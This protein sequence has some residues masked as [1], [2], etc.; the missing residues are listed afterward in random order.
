MPFSRAIKRSLGLGAWFLIAAI[1][2]SHA[3]DLDALRGQTV[4]VIIGANAGGTTDTSAR[5]F[6]DFVKALLPE[7]TMRIQNMG[8]SGAAA[9]VKE[10]Q[11][12][13]GSV[14]TIA[15]FNYGPIYNQLVSPEL[16]PYDLS[17][18]QWIGAMERVQRVLAIRSGLGG[19]TIDA[20]RGLDR[21][22]VIGASDAS[23][24]STIEAYLINAMFGLGVRV[25]QG[26]SD[27]Q[28]EVLLLAG[29]IEAEIGNPFEMSPKF[30]SGAEIPVLRFSRDTVLNIEGVPA[31]ADIAPADVPDELIF[32]FETLDKTGRLVTASPATDP[33]VVASLRAA[34]DAVTADPEFV[35]AMAGIDIAV[36]PT[37]GPELSERLERLLGPESGNLQQIL[38]SYL[39]CG[40]RMSAEGVTACM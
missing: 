16:A 8:G 25:L 11:E 17:R 37:N 10:V 7:T 13:E 38:Q 9:A 34:F 21:R 3:D 23:S 33:A 12:A 35:A 4:R 27:S 20:L 22:A 26:S 39:E 15:I 40:R 32:F 1:V 6:L 14:V 31:I 19:T 5:M 29:E 28:N 36:V 30:E 24:P 2:P 18:L